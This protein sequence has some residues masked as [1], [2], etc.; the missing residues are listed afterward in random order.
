MEEAAH[1]L[2]VGR[3]SRKAQRPSTTPGSDKEKKKKK[4]K[5]EEEEEEEEKKKKELLI[6]QHPHRH[7]RQD[8]CNVRLACRL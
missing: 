2:P 5:K 1:T 3:T 6:N 8:V 7:M 4:K